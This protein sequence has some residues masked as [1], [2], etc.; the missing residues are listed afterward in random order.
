MAIFSCGMRKK[1]R[2]LQWPRKEPA[3]LNAQLMKNPDEIL[4]GI[5]GFKY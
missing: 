1:K 5:F 2:R 3:A 4:K